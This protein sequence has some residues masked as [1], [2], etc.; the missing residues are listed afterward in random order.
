[1][2]PCI[3][4][5]L[6]QHLHVHVHVHVATAVCVSCQE[7]TSTLR[8]GNRA[9][10]GEEVIFTCTL[11]GSLALA[12]SS[13]G[14]IE[15]ASPLQFSTASTLGRDVTSMINGRITATARLT[16]NTNVTGVRILESTLRITAV[17]AS[18]VT[19]RGTT[20]DTESIEFSVSGTYLYNILTLT[21][22]TN[23]W[24]MRGRQLV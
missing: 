9:C 14:Y 21:Y 10:Q 8:E 15:D 17:V 13:P 23:I 4:L 3:P 18:L 2:T 16:R 7:L 22:N 19:C 6:L 1:V 11:R 20:G 24:G 5:P 12:W